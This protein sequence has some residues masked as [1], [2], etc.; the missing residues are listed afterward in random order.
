MNDFCLL[1]KAIAWKE[2]NTVFYLLDGILAEYLEGEIESS[3]D[4]FNSVWKSLDEHKSYEFAQFSVFNDISFL[5]A[6]IVN[7][8]IKYKLETPEEK[9]QRMSIHYSARDMITYGG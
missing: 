7:Y 4:K 6:F 8:K 9:A 1:L 5:R 3:K 2:W